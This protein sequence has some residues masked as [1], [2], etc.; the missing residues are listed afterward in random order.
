[1]NYKTAI[2]LLVAMVLALTS[3]TNVAEGGQ[4]RHGADRIHQIDRDRTFDR[5]RRRDRDR[6]ETRE[7]SRDRGRF[8]IRDP[9]QMKDQDIYGHEFMTAK[10]CN[11]YRHQLG[12]ADTPDAQQKFQAQH[13]EMMQKRA[14]DQGG[15]LVPP[16]QEPVYGGELMTVQERNRYRERLRWLDAGDER[17]KLLARHRDRMDER[18]RALGYK[19]KEAR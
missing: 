17:E 5:D 1:M 7:H 10:E 13:E 4:Q 16:G 15:D 19:I 11:Q 18:A 12:S 9:S 3:L 8:D 14:L 6:T 2:S